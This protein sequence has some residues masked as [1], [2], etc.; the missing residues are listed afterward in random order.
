MVES[1]T[2]GYLSTACIRTDAY[3]KARMALYRTKSD[4]T[5]ALGQSGLEIRLG[6][7]AVFFVRPLYYQREC[8]ALVS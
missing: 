1:K 6:D 3:W 4:S 7:M 5:I 8:V 2:M